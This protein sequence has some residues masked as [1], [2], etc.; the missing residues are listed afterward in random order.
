MEVT[1]STMGDLIPDIMEDLINF[2]MIRGIR[3]FGLARPSITSPFET[4]HGGRG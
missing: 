2:F 4:G 1:L 3:S